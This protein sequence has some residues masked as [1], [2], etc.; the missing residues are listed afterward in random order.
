[1]KRLLLCVL[2]CTASACASAFTPKPIT[3]ADLQRQA[4]AQ[5]GDGPAQRDLTLAEMFMADGDLARAEQALHRARALAPKSPELVL[6]QGLLADLHGQPGAALDAYLAAIEQAIASGDP[7]Q[8][9]LVEATSYAVQGQNG[10]AVGYAQR[11]R[12]RLQ[13]LADKPGLALSAR[14][15]L[16]DVLIPLAYRR[17]DLAEVKRLSA[18]LGCIT[19]AR[20]IGPF[21]PRELLGFDAPPP[22]DLAQPL[23]AQYDLGPSRGVRATRAVQAQGCRLNVGGGP[24][25]DGG[26]HMVEAAVQI[27]E[28]GTYTLRLDT[29]NSAELFVDGQSVLRVDRRTRLG[30]R[31]VLKQVQLSAGTHRV[32]IRLSSRHPNPVVELAFAAATRDDAEEPVQSDAR[33]AVPGFDLYMRVAVA[34]ARGD[35]LEGRQAL[36][37][38]VL[39]KQASP[40]LLLQ[41][42]GIALSD[43]LMPEGVRSDEARGYLARAAARDTAAWAPVLQLAAL[44]A[45]AGR[46]KESIAVLRKA[47]E[48]WPEVPAIGLSLADLLRSKEFQAAA[49]EVIAQVRERVPDACAPMTA[50]LEALRARQRYPE[51]VPLAQELVKCDAQNTALYSLYLEQR[52]FAAAQKE[53]ARLDALTPD[54]GRYATLLSRIALAKN[55]GDSA[56]VTSLV[57]ELRKDYPRSYAG[58]IEQIDSLAAAGQKGEALAALARATKAEPAAMAG[59]YRA[60]VG[61]GQPHPLEAYRKDGL[62]AIKAFEASGKT[63]P[64]PQVLVL[65]YMALRVFE[66]GSSL[67]L[68]HTVQR[69]QSDEAVDQL[70]EVEVPEGAQVLT[71]RA[72]K[73]DGRVLE[74]DSIANK[75]TVS[76]PK[77]APGDYIELEFLDAKAPADGFPGGYLGERFYFKSFEIPFHH[78]Q[79]VLQLPMDMPYQIDPRGTPPAKVEST[80]DGLRVLDFTVDESEPLIAE[81]G[82]VSAR[83]FIPSVRLGVRATFEALIESLRDVLADRALFDPY[84]EKLAQQIVG[85]A[86]PSDYRLRAERLYDWVIENIENSNDVFAQAALMLRAKAGN[87]ARVL[88][89]LLGLVGVPAE[90][91]LARDFGSDRFD[92]AMAD[93]DTYDHL[94]LLVDPKGREPLWL[95]ANERW[96]PFGFIPAPLR[97]Q[98]A[99]LMA[100]GAPQLTVSDGLLGPD[101]RRFAIAAQLQTDGAARIDVTESLHGADAVAWRSQLEQ[102]PQAELNRRMEQ[103][104][105]SRLFPGA[106]LVELKIEGGD[107]A[108]PDLA[109]KYVLQ[110]RNFARPVAGGLALPSIL[111]SEI[112][113]NFARVAARKT[114]ELIGNPLRTEL[115]LLIQLPAGFA[116]ANPPKPETL[117]GDFGGT[118]T[119]SEKISADKAGLRLQRTLQV[120]AMRIEPNVYPA[121]SNFCRQVD[122]AEGRE[123]FLQR[124]N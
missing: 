19:Q 39:P 10:L 55:L 32:Y 72:I 18:R 94:L 13:P 102:I 117:S 2:V 3:L 75:N 86:A 62:A 63:Y 52:D 91:A 65:D 68:V 15:A 50:Q 77:V 99:L 47:S 7:A 89:Y 21:G 44:A 31:V 82:S 69:A 119:F 108:T 70:G 101:V 28:G 66:D 122:A 90:L 121:F 104:Y 59:L 113:A 114:T 14:A 109:L 37:D 64:G 8:L 35:L 23:A 111:P 84:Y 20:A 12:D 25:A 120:P 74:A 98:P 17:G 100:A 34:L 107:T 71:L 57:N 9:P 76:L 42:A 61:L 54:S 40:L 112:S 81:P 53:L 27:V 73:P 26:M 36:A 92:G 97:K 105:V 45:K 106:S 51:I 5:P 80:R 79:M 116:L 38:A 96:A 43:P 1:M 48:K 4:E 124:G 87:R 115:D 60:G 123:L 11:T 6:A 103:D 85:D 41:R 16:L 29:P 22:I 30:A 56:S 83:E 110:V 24:V 49:D 67:E 118:P 95:F 46:V 93:A 78:S 33:R 88:H 58:A